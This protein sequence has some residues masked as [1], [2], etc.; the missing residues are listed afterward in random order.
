MDFRFGLVGLAAIGV[1]A[2]CGGAAGSAGSGWPDPASEVHTADRSS[3]VQISQ[4]LSEVAPNSA[5]APVA[6]ET[7]KLDTRCRIPRA[8]GSDKIVRIYS[9]G[10]GTKSPLFQAY[11]SVK[12]SGVKN[13]QRTDVIVTETEQPVYL[14]LD[15]YNAVLW[16]L[17]VAEGAK[18]SG[19]FVNSYEGSA[20]SN[21]PKGTSVGMAAFRGTDARSCRRK[22]GQSAPA[23]TRVAAAK[24]NTGYVATA[25]DIKKWTEEYRTSKKRRSTE[26]PKWIGGRIDVDIFPDGSDSYDA[27]LIGPVPAVPFAATPISSVMIGDSVDVVWADRKTALAYLDELAVQQYESMR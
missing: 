3:A 25:R 20:I 2:G 13:Y 19:V 14:V 26:V 16:N 18:V 24:A 7:I 10:G 21:V 17:Q 8:S 27:A 6:F 9:Y 1:L 15:S 12:E 4:V 5:S 23:E 22:M 11:K